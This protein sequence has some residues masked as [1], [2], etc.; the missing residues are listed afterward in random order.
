ML[1]AVGIRRHKI[2]RALDDWG[3][4]ECV[5][6]HETVLRVTLVQASNVQRGAGIYLE[7]WTEPNDDYPKNSRVHKPAHGAIDFGGELLEID[8]HGDEQELVIHAVEYTGAASKQSKDLPFCELRIP[9]TSIEKYAK[10]AQAGDGG[11]AGT[12]AFEMRPLRRADAYSR[13]FR[14][15]GM[16]PSF[17]MASVISKIG[18]EQ[19]L[20]IPTQAEL[21]D[22]QA[23]NEGLRQENEA[24]RSWAGPN[25]QTECGEAPGERAMTGM[26]MAVHFEIVPRAKVSNSQ[27]KLIR[28]ASFQ[29]S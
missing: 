26:S 7:A 12:R 11:G 28:K 8:W 23:E 13:R 6:E 25:C 9:R 27:H 22:L 5:P 18:A 16:L 2:L 1:A 20:Y 4:C 10:E 29:E 17:I 3:L 15:Q 19:G 14:F 21:G 24:L